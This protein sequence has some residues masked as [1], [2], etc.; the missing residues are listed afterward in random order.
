MTPAVVRHSDLR[1][2]QR[3]A[4]L[5]RWRAVWDEVHLRR[6]WRDHHS[7]VRPDGSVGRE[8]VVV[9][10]RGLFRE[11][12]LAL[13]SNVSVWVV[14]VVL[15]E[16][17]RRLSFHLIRSDPVVAPRT[18]Q[19]GHGV[20]GVVAL[21]CLIK[22]ASQLLAWLKEVPPRFLPLLLVLKRVRSCWSVWDDGN[23]GFGLR[24]NRSAD[25]TS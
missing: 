12:G 25:L 5:R 23:A 15:L 24:K 3:T 7:H 4:D 22:D 6:D 20:G 11:L 13:S 17:P 19:A 2:L 14:P 9:H 8:I 21:V 16:V 18:E 10:Q 1:V